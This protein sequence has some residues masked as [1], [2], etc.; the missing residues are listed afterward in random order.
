MYTMQEENTL[1]TN[2][3]KEEIAEKILTIQFWISCF[4]AYI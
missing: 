1:I 2:K 3:N 4:Q